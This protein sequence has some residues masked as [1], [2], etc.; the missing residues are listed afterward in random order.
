[1]FCESTGY[2]V[3]ECRKVTEVSERR[4]KLKSAHRCFLCLNRGHKARICSRNGRV[5][6]TRCKGAH[7]R[8][9]CNDAGAATTSTKETTPSTV[10]KIDV[11]SNFTYLQTARIWVMGPTGRSKLTRCVL[12]GG[13]QSSFI[14]KNLIDDLKLE[15]V[16]CRDLV[17]STFESRSS[18]SGSRRVVRFGAKSI[19]NNTTVPITAFEST[20]VFCP[21]PTVPRDI[22]KMAQTSK[23]QLADPREG[24]RDLPI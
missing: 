17:V 15:V 21:H 8:S 7:H 6:C 4:E 22:T 12:D 23:I 24:E 3:Q 18:G 20:H 2:W 11:T 13:N 14:A 16:G 10:G 9:I 5:S 19:W 1:V